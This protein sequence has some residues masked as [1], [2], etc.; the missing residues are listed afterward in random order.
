MSAHTGIGEPSRA[1]ASAVSEPVPSS[2]EPGAL[3]PGGAV[4][5]QVVRRL[6]EEI[7]TG[8]LLPGAKLAEVDTARRLGVSRN[9]LREA[10]R[11]LSRQTLVVHVPNRGVFVAKP[12]LA[13]MLDLYRARLILEPA[14]MRAA[15]PAHPAGAKMRAAIARA[16]QAAAHGDWRR[17]GTENAAFHAAVVQLA[18]SPSLDAFHDDLMVRLRLVFD[19]VGDPRHLHES[20]VDSNDRITAAYEA[21]DLDG[22]AERLTDYLEHSRALVIDV[23]AQQQADAE[24]P[25]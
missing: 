15:S 10:F 14:I 20:Y 19:M 22:A 8:E 24:R 4:G 3:D 12:T 18:G 16:R 11:L 17:V 25:A 23:Y 2:P 13:N 6:R 7:S 9:T 21:G 1:T 5:E